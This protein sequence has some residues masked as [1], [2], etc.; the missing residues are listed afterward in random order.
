MPA[1]KLTVPAPLYEIFL[2]A[3]DVS[4]VILPLLVAKVAVLPAP[5]PL[6]TR[7]LPAPSMAMVLA[8]PV[9]LTE[10][11]LK[12][13]ICGVEMDVLP[14]VCTVVLA[15]IDVVVAAPEVAML[16]GPPVR[17]IV[18]EVAEPFRPKVRLLPAEGLTP[19]APPAVVMD[20]VEGAAT[21]FLA[22]IVRAPAEPMVTP[23]PVPLSLMAAPVLRISEGV[24]TETVPL[25]IV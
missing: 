19:M 17:L 22:D 1:L 10:E 11:L 18:P 16:T 24:V 15:L 9:T 3:A 12:R 14:L 5:G 13:L 2:D 20:T 8:A 25:F 4:T 23:V 6:K 21:V 7:L